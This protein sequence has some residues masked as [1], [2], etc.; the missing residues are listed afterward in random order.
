MATKRIIRISFWTLILVGVAALCYVRWD[1]WFKNPTTQPWEGDR[2]PCRF[3]TF[4]SGVAL[5]GDTTRI[6]LLGDVHNQLRHEDY[7]SLALRFP[8]LSALAQ[9]G[10][11]MDRCT[12][13]HAQ[14]LAHQMEGNALRTLPVLCCPGNHEYIKGLH[15]S[16]EPR[17]LQMFPQPQNGPENYQGTT[18]YVDFPTLRYIVI[19]T[20]GLLLL[21]EYTRVVTWLR[22]V[23]ADAGSRQTV[24]MMHHPVLSTAH[25]RMNAMLYAV[26]RTTLGKADLVISGHDHNYARR[27]PFMAMASV[28]GRVRTIG[29]FVR[30]DVTGCEPVCALLE[31]TSLNGKPQLRVEVYSI[32]HPHLVDS[33]TINR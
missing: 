21:R 11:W 14:L 28:P 32:H 23:L 15:P 1:A 22:G 24:V 17:W 29:S 10:D 6:L 33:F 31:A 12:D 5:T 25:Y 7:D 4:A 19:D 27:L 20:Q 30:W 3:E 26:F 8:R 18:Y 16:V 2:L 9:T 13:Y